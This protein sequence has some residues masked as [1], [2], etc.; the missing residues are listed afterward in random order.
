MTFK[1]RKLN[2][3]TIQA[4][5]TKFLNSMTFMVFHDLYGPCSSQG[6][7]WTRGL[8]VQ[9]SYRSAGDA[10]SSYLWFIHIYNSKLG[11]EFQIRPRSQKLGTLKY[12]L[13]HCWV[14]QVHMDWS[15]ACASCYKEDHWKGN[16]RAYPFEKEPETSASSCLVSPA[17]PET[18]ANTNP[19]RHTALL[20]KRDF[21][22]KT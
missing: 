1:D 20:L 17:R 8:Q 16:L 11:L 10:A 14:F 3:M 4:L 2:S 9:R 12:W 18:H 6:G 13:I 21:I 7:T 5:K 19:V 22:S 15:S